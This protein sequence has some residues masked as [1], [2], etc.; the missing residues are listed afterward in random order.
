MSLIEQAKEFATL[1][2]EGQFRKHGKRPYIYHP[3]RVATYLEEKNYTGPI[4][5]AAWLHDVLEDCPFV[6]YDLLKKTFG[7]TVANL[8]REVTHPVVEG[9]SN[10]KQRWEIYLDHY[11]KASHEGKI[12]KLADRVCNLNEYAD[13]WDD[14]PVKDRKFLQDVYLAESWELFEAMYDVDPYII[15]FDFHDVLTHLDELCSED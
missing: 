4:I 6:S 15:G 7:E 2:H 1:A 11:A 8:V 14:V 12:L 10:R 3:G 9:Y 5:A 13:Y